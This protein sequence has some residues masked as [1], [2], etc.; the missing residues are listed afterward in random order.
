M[1]IGETYVDGQ[2]NDVWCDSKR[3]ITDTTMFITGLD[4]DCTF[5]PSC[6]HVQSKN[7]QNLK[8]SGYNMCTLDYIFPNLDLMFACTVN[9]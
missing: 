7:M 1:H 9:N 4:T 8:K 6:Y 3:K 2:F 5:K